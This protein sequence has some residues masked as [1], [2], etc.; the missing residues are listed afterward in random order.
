VNH[1]C[2]L[3]YSVK[4]NRYYLVI[5]SGSRNLG[6]RVCDYY[7][8]RAV[9]L[10]KSEDGAMLCSKELAYIPSDSTSYDK[11]LY[12]A[13]IICNRY[14]AYNRELMACSIMRDFLGIK[15]WRLNYKN[16]FHCVHNYIG[17]MGSGKI[18]RKGA[19]SAALDEQVIIP[20]NMRDG[21]ILGIGK[22]N[23]EWNQSAPH[24]AG[25]LMSR[26]KAK[27]ELNMDNF[28]KSMEGIYTT[29]VNEGTLDESPMAYKDPEM[30]KSMISGTVE[31]TDIIKPVYNF[32]ATEKKR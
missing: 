12:D 1:F 2:E 29:S 9:E 31:I 7:Q 3:D 4:H 15:G 23:P 27:K 14:A 10:S 20:L 13:G 18:I 17:T 25:R 21:C 32:K 11:Y 19:I 6:A 16:G 30:I 24:G 8:E 5:H 22:G 28:R 26:S